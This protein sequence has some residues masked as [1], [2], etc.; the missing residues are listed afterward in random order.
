MSE[1]TKIIVI[2]L[3]A[4]EI[5]LLL[6]P[7][8]LPLLRRLKFGQT[9]RNE[10]PESH[11]AKNGTP[12]MGGIMIMIAFTIPCIFFI[13]DHEEIFAPCVI[14]I[15][16]GFVGFLDDYLKVKR[17]KSEGLKPWQKMETHLV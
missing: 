6:A 16:F 11:L 1:T 13:K 12:T 2:F 8:G 15:L 4:F 10:G 5:M 3:A 7:A 9:V 14:A 17:K